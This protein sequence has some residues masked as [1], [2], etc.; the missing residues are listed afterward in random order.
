MSAP[1]RPA[2][3]AALSHPSSRST[4]RGGA[5]RLSFK[6]TGLKDSIKRAVPLHQLG[7][8]FW[9]DSGS[10]RQFIRGV[11]AERDEVRHSVWIDAVSLPDLLR[12]DARYFPARDGYR[13]VVHG[14]A[15]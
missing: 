3:A 10:A 5:S 12:P 2:R 8:A 13:I 7:R 6:E 4:D 1:D 14:E 11:T 15:S 9:P